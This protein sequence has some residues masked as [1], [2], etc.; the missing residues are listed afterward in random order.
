MGM[1]PAPI[2]PEGAPDCATWVGGSGCSGCFRWMGGEACAVMALEYDLCNDP[3][4]H[5]DDVVAFDG[6]K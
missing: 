1:P 2:G 3:C 6:V 5:F 4:L